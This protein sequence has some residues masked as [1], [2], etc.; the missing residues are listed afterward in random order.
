MEIAKLIN[1]YNYFDTKHFSVGMIVLRTVMG[2][3]ALI[4]FYT[5][6]TKKSPQ[7]ERGKQSVFFFEL[8]GKALEKRYKIFF[9]FSSLISL[10]F[11]TFFLLLFSA[12]PFDL[13]YRKVLLRLENFSD[14]VKD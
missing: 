1:Y 7:I 9:F 12:L 10:I 4:K 2:T 6:E 13:N 14:F 8:R 11:L 3:A 5:F